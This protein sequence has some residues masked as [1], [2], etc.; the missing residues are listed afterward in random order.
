MKLYKLTCFDNET[1]NNTLWGENVTHTANGKGNKLCTED[2]IHAY[3]HPLIAAFMR[4]HHVPIYYNKLW[5]CEGEAI[6]DDGT[7][8]GCKSLTTLKEVT[9]PELTTEQRVKIAIL[10]AKEVYK[11]KKWNEWADGWLSG[12]RSRELALD[13]CVATRADANAAYYAASAAY[14]YDCDFDF[15]DDYIAADAYAA[16]YAARAAAAS[17]DKLDLLSIIRKAC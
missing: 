5:E 7:K 11:E 4:P 16:G 8:V 9:L 6:T 14:D 1:K 3:R 17:S 2:F 13:A 15:A 12:K 10:C